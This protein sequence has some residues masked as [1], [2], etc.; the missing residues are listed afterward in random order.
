MAEKAVNTA[1]KNCPI[2]LNIEI[3]LT[4]GDGGMPYQARSATRGYFVIPL[5]DCQNCPDT[6]MN[7]F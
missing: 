5:W 6:L 4:W 2:A 7:S 1:L 3:L